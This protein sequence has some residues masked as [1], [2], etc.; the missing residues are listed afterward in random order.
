M[1]IHGLDELNDLDLV[2]HPTCSFI[3]TLRGKTVISKGKL[4][5]VT[6]VCFKKTVI[7]YA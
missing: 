5:L 7:A 2:Y 4:L 3:G 6:F 1:E